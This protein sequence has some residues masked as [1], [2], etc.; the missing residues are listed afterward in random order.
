MRL[1]LSLSQNAT[2]LRRIGDVVLF[3]G[4]FVALLLL[5]SS[6]AFAASAQHSWAIVLHGGAGV[7]ERK[8]MDPKT[9]AA[10]RAGL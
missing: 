6:E 7:I 3:C 9:E 10:Y 1:S 8:S 4:V 2:F 5:V